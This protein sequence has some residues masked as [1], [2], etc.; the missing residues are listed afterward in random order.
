KPLKK[1]TTHVATFSNLGTG[2]GRRGADVRWGVAGRMAVAWLIT[3]PS[4]GLVGAA[5]WAIAHLIGGLPGVLVVFAILLMMAGWMY[6][7]SRRQPIDPSNVN[8][9]WD[10]GLI[11]A[12]HIPGPPAPPT[13]A[14]APA[15]APTPSNNVKA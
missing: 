3:L 13:A 15:P 5:C 12:E 8:A 10:G 4:A 11:P 1:S 7:R 14:P 9:D 2:V 6:A